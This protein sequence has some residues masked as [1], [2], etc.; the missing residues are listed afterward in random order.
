MNI[1][2]IYPDVKPYDCSKWKVIIQI[3]DDKFIRRGRS[4]VNYINTNLFTILI[5]LKHNNLEINL[6]DYEIQI[7]TIKEIVDVLKGKSIDILDFDNLSLFEEVFKYASK[8]K[9]KLFVV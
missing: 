9:A 8:Y 7:Y 1:I 5:A 4:Y 3:G 6:N 2:K